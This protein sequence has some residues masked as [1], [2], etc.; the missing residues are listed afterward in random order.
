VVVGSAGSHVA[1][2]DI[3]QV[4]GA[5]A[6]IGFAD[7]LAFCS[8]SSSIGLMDERQAGETG[9]ARGRSSRPAFF[10]GVIVAGITF[11]VFSPCL[12]FGFVGW[13]DLLVVA[14]N[15]RYNPPT[16]ESVG[17]YWTHRGFNLY[18]PLTYSLW[19]VL[20]KLSGLPTPGPAGVR[21]DP[22]LFHLTSV[23]LQTITAVAVFAI[24]I[25]IVRSATAAA[26]GAIAFAIHPLMTESV[27]FI[28]IINT[29]LAGALS[30]TAVWLYL[31][32]DV[33]GRGRFILAT[34][35]YALSLLARPSTVPIPLAAL[36]LDMI[37]L[38][39]S[40]RQ[41]IWSIVPW[42]LITI[43]CVVWT[44][45]IQTGPELPVSMLAHLRFAGFA[46]AFYLTKIFWPIP[47]GV[48]YGCTPDWMLSHAV[49]ALACTVPVAM[50][51]LAWILRKKRPVIAVALVVYLVMLLPNSGLVPFD[52]QRVSNVADRY[53]Y[54]GLVAL[55]LVISAVLARLAPGIPR[56]VGYGVT[57][58]VLLFWMTLTT[59]QLRTWQ[60]GITLFS[61]A[62]EVNPQSPFSWQCLAQVELSADHPAAALKAATRSIDLNPAN[63]QFRLASHGSG[64][65][66][67]P[68]GYASAWAEAAQGHVA[69]ANALDELNRLKEAAAE[70]NIAVQMNPGNVLAITDLA[71]VLGRS[72]DDQQA[73]AL[74]R[75]ALA[76]DPSF[77][78]ARA[79]LRKPRSDSGR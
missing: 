71:F 73:Q 48:D 74:L 64:T 54:L 2:R 45:I 40:P 14:G 42:V 44:R 3:I 67:P 66:V 61:H 52:F 28:G 20:A 77:A 7:H 1:P 22:F 57:I 47:L 31:S 76:I 41:A 70:L 25:R 24:L 21:M 12:F 43:P 32:R 63:E 33:G 37:A 65:I 55:A 69:K 46:G 9:S 79:A 29:P 60:N 15:P 18:Q 26:L 6:A 34:T 13:D 16:L 78:P 17:F 4:K 59:L 30:L 72:G 50:L 58:I 56:R 62:V 19:G 38:R 39:R 51:V 27:A 75:R 23:L 49:T 11:I 53:A 68:P 5:G 35:L 36:L 8:A 10:A